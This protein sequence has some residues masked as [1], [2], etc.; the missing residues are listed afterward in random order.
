MHLVSKLQTKLLILQLPNPLP[1]Y[2]NYRYVTMHSHSTSPPR[3]RVSR[4]TSS[5]PKIQI[6]S[7]QDTT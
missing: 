6:V 3:T 2:V 1:V 5:E 7:I 4:K